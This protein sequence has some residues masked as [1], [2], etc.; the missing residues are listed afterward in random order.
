M[1]KER[2]GRRKKGR[3]SSA[4][5]CAPSTARKSPSFSSTSS[6]AVRW[7]ATSSSVT[8]PEKAFAAT[9][10]AGTVPIST[11]E[12]GFGSGGASAYLGSG[13]S[14]LGLGSD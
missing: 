6:S 3:E 1:G 9:R 5:T 2:G 13:S 7:R 8:R 4:L 10:R 12:L 14:G 11:S